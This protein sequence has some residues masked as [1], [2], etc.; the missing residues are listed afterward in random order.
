MTKQNVNL[1]KATKQETERGN[2]DMDKKP[3]ETTLNIDNRL[4]RDKGSGVTSKDGLIR[5]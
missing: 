5:E 3:K 2:S 1:C 4:T